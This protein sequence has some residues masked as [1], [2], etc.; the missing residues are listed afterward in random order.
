MWFV[1]IKPTSL[2]FDPSLPPLESSERAKREAKKAY[3]GLVMNGNVESRFLYAMLLSTDLL[4]FGHLD[5]R[6]VVLPIEPFQSHKGWRYNLLDAEN[7]RDKGYP[8]L[9][10]WLEDAEKEWDKRRKTKKT[11]L[12]NYLDYRHKLTN[13]NSQTRYRVLYN[14]AGTY[15]TAGVLEN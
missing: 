11:N 8:R 15:L 9:S 6:I 4:P 14:T 5:Y 2:G 1:E 7:A 12:L 3:Q 13:Q 10:K